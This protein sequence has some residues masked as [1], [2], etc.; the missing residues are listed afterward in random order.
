MMPSPAVR[1]GARASRPPPP[2]GSRAF[3][4]DTPNGRS[5][6]RVPGRPMVQQ[7]CPVVLAAPNQGQRFGPRIPDIVRDVPAVLPQPPERDR[8]PVA[9][10]LAPE[11]HD[12]GGRDE[13]LHHGPA[14]EGQGLAAE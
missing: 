14:E 1:P 9:I 10:A 5:P 8:R 7:K 13:E 3:R 12:E 11:R 2:P 4:P 6:G